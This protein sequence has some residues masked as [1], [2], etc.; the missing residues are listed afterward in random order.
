MVEKLEKDV[1][2][3]KMQKLSAWTLSLDSR[4]IERSFKFKDFR[5]AFAFM[6]EVA[7][8]AEKIK[9]HPEWLNVYNHVMIRLTTHEC[10]G[11]TQKDMDLARHI[12]KVSQQWE[13]K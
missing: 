7:I 3:A 2:D 10:E 6:T 13:V 9:H 11:L 12:D 8:W 5:E 1:I 4:A